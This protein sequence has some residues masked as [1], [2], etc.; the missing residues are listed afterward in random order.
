M[1]A[2]DIQHAG[3]N[4]DLSPEHKIIRQAAREFAINEI[5]PIAAKF[6]ETGDFPIDT[7]RK[8]GKMGLMGILLHPCTGGN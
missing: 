5:A 3:P 4:L 6:D 2:I 8:M 7:I 1:S